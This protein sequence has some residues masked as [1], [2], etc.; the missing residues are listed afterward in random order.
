[1]SCFQVGARR[2][3]RK[4]VLRACG[5]ALFR[6]VARRWKAGELQ[7]DAAYWGFNLSDEEFADHRS[8]AETAVQ[9]R[10]A[11]EAACLLQ[12]ARF[13]LV[14]AKDKDSRV[15]Y[16]GRLE[17]LVYLCN[18][19]EFKGFAMTLNSLEMVWVRASECEDVKSKIRYFFRERTAECLAKLQEAFEG[20]RRLLPH[21]EDF[22]SVFNP[23]KFT[24]S[25]HLFAGGIHCSA[26]TLLGPEVVGALWLVSF[27]ANARL[28]SS[29]LEQERIGIIFAM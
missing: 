19:A 9:K 5:R 18:L 2:L 10:A 11:V 20:G 12:K 3:G 13:G 7:Y 6:E 25:Y 17:F 1:M 29:N 23:I 15:F 27:L 16:A 28:H 26:F 24:P 8:F 4:W 22:L 14:A 21:A